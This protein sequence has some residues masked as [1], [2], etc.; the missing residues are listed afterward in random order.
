MLG[1]EALYRLTPDIFVD[2]IGLGFTYPVAKYFGGCKILSYTHY[3]TITSDMINLVE[4]RKEA[5]N[6][7]GKIAK[8]HVLT[9]LK[10][11]YYKMFAVI[12]RLCGR[13]ADLVLANG[14]FTEVHLKNLWNMPN[15]ILLKYIIGIIKLYPPCDCNKFIKLPLGNRKNYIV[16]IGQFRPEKNYPL[17]LEA[18]RLLLDKC[19]KNTEIYDNLKLILIGGS[20]NK[21]DE[22][23]ISQYKRLAEQLGIS[24]KVEFKVNVF[25][26]IYN[27]VHMMNY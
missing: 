2:T 14:T 17:Q 19:E 4:E 1:M 8:S 18:F 24:D 6:N 20:R 3:P 22:D 15:S 27:S 10:V 21:D 23:R 11:L 26:N 5:H 25:F 16:S 7:S 13:S 12:Y 9:K